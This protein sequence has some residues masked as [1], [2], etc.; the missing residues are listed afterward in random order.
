[1]MRTQGQ[2]A[3]DALVAA[4]AVERGEA[5][6]E[7]ARRYA[8][9]LAAVT[10]WAREFLCQPHPA[11]GRA[12]RVCPYAQPALDNGTFWLTVLPG[13]APTPA[14]IAAAVAACRERFTSLAPRSGRDAQFKT[15]LLVFPEL[16]HRDA[17]ALVDGVQRRL[18]PAFVARG[19]MLGQFHR[20]CDEPG[21]WNPAFRPLRSPVP[22]LAIRHLVP[23]DFPFLAH[24]PRCVASYL[25]IIGG[26]TPARLR[27]MVREAAA[28]FGLRCPVSLGKEQG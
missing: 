17:P 19:L 3:A 23:T 1:M 6:P 5:L 16:D 8:A 4:R 20:T 28:R 27:R 15:I 21:L 7:P 25:R 22:L 2:V 9:Q 11:L 14:E 26:E 12:G 10:Q 13:A 18:K 24:D